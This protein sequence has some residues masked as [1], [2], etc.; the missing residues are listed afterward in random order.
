MCVKTARKRITGILLLSVLLLAGVAFAAFHEEIVDVLF[1]VKNDWK[2]KNGSIYYMDE[3][4]EPVIGWFRTDGYD[5]YLNPEQGGAMTTGWLRFEDAVYYL[6]EQGRM[7]T[8]WQTIEEE[9]YY[10]D[11]D[12][13]MVTGFV[14]LETGCYYLGEDGTMK[15]G[16]LELPE[17]TYYLGEDGRM[18][19]GWLDLDEKKY[20]FDESGTRLT[21]VVWL[22]EQAYYVPEDGV[23][24]SGWVEQDGSTY[25][26]YEDGAAA[27]GWLELEEKKY[28]LDPETATLVT[29][30]VETEQGRYYIA[31]DGTAAT[32]WLELDGARYYCDEDNALTTGWLELDGQN[33][34]FDDDGV[35]AVGKVQIGEDIHY[36]TS[37]GANILLV[38]RW[39]PVPEDYEPKLVTFRGWQVDASCYDDLVKMLSDCPYGYTITSAYRSASSQQSIWNKRLATYKANGYSA[40]TAEKMVADY[41]AMP[42]T[43]EH[44]L[45][46]AVDI[47]GAN[48]QKWLEEHCWEYG[49]ILRYLDGKSEI[50]GIAYEK[51][52]FR[53][54]GAELAMEMKGTG[55]CLEE[56]LDRLTDDGTTC[57]NPEAT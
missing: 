47:S 52:H 28:Y 53:Y 17:G 8:G 48:A 32:G 24:A 12:G 36:F 4:G 39:N 13:S 46:L 54:V 29:G 14:T 44:Q 2:E 57:G 25:Y 38:N 11:E 23:M 6:G 50:T 5:Y 22:N 31:E 20:Y 51:W 35:M 40:A 10:F 18:A 49:F 9:R 42:G 26:L 27:T 21:G 37:T 43:S 3:D 55:L 45:G 30:W 34:Y 19:V 56:Y 33:Y 7:C 15:T 1:P 41:V 16:W